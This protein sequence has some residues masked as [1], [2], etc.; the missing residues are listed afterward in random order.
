MD[1]VRSHRDSYCVWA[2]TFPLQSPVPSR[3]RPVST[4]TDKHQYFE[5]SS[6]ALSKPGR[7]VPPAL[8]PATCRCNLSSG[9]GGYHI[10]IRGRRLTRRWHIG[11]YFERLA[12]FAS[13][14][15]APPPFSGI[16]WIP[17]R[18]RAATSFSAVS[19]RPPIAS[20]VSYDSSLPMVG[21]ETPE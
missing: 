20:A 7:K 10:D 8:L 14:T 5:P 9:Y 13:R 21:F 2:R 16:N 4:A 19:R 1:G 6:N 17:A 18:S 15:P 12:R 11:I 3:T